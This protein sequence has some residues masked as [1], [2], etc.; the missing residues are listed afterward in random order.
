MGKAVLAVGVV[1]V[2]VALMIARRV[3]GEPL[4]VRRLLLA[5]LF[6][7]AIGGYQIA[8]HG[9]LPA[10]EWLS[11]ALTGAL[12]LGL[13]AARGA[14]VELFERRGVLW[15]RYRLRTFGVW[16]AAFVARFGVRA[17]LAVL[18]VTT[19]AASISSLASGG[20]PHFSAALIGTLLITSGL[21]FLGESLVLT[22]RALATGVPLQPSGRTGS[23]LLAILDGVRGGDRPAGGAR[24]RR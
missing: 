5:P 2:V 22:P 24:R 23:P 18:G 6:E 9:G 3:Y 11:L 7:L 15:Q 13:G 20:K 4:K 10:G 1:L 17:L 12:S 8:T 21:G 19:A 16:L 14:T